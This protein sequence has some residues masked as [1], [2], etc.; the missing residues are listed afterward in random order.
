MYRNSGKKTLFV[1]HFFFSFLK[2]NP[3]SAEVLQQFPEVLN[4]SSSE[5]EEAIYSKS[6]D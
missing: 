4:K 6:N 5:V 3:Y 2:F 1:E